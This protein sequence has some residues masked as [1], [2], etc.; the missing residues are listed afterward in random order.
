M[1]IRFRRLVCCLCFAV[2]MSLLNLSAMAW[3]AA[4]HMT[5]A[6]IA[7][8][9]LNAATRTK[10]IELIREHPRF[11]DHF[12]RAMPKEVSSGNKQ[13]QDEW[14]FAFA[15]TWP[16]TVRESKFGVTRQDVSQFS[17]PWW[18]FIDM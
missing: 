8:D 1:H 16:D 4:G 13:E 2:F 10:A 14:L 15:S 11:H 6:L 9:Q 3:N 5:I 18:H 7:Y 12:Q 17:R